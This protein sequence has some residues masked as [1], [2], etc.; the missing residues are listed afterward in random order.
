MRKTKESFAAKQTLAT[1]TSTVAMGQAS[2]ADGYI[3]DLPRCIHY[4]Q[5]V[6]DKLILQSHVESNS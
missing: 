4:S 6:K 3:L 2:K 1:L 5:E